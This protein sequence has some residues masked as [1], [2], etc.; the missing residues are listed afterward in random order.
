MKLITSGNMKLI[1]SGKKIKD[2]QCQHAYFS[3][4]MAAI[5]LGSPYLQLY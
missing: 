5:S 4:S 1:T 2:E 3:A